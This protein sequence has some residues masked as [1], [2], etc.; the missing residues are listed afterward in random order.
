MNSLDWKEIEIISRGKR[1]KGRYSVNV[2][3]NFVTVAAWCGTKTARLGIL[4]AERV[5]QM[6]L[7]DIVNQEQDK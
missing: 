4:P 7:R 3:E 5:A 2:A 6:L 1:V